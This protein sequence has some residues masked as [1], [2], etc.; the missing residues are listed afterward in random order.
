MKARLVYPAHRPQTYWSF[1]GA[2]P[3]I[4]RRAA[5]G[6][7]DVDDSPVPRFDILEAS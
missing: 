4:E 7:P 6:F 1:S 3:Y 2:L 5:E